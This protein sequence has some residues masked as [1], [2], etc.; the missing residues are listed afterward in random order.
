M[1]A[2][3][4]SSW[5]RL[6]S[7]SSQFAPL[8]PLL[9]IL[10]NELLLAR[11]EGK[12]VS[13]ALL[14]QKHPELNSEEAV[15]L[16]YEEFCLKRD[17]GE[18]VDSTELINKFP[19]FQ[20]QLKTVLE[21]EKLLDQPRPEPVFPEPGTQVGPFH[22]I[23]RLGRGAAGRTYLAQEKSL[24]NRHVV[25]KIMPREQQ[26]HL[27]LARLQHTHIMPLFSELTLP[28]SG[29][30][31]LCMPYLGG[32]GLHEILAGLKE[33]GISKCTG[34]DFL[35]TLDSLSGPEFQ[36]V[37]WASPTRQSLAKSTY[38]DT[39]AS[40]G[41]S[42]A[43]AAHEAHARG[44]V[45]MDIKPS[46]ILIS[47]DSEPLL[48]DFHLARKPV[49]EG[50]QRVD[51]LGGTRGWMSPE[52][53][54]C[55]EAARHGQPM[56][57]SIDG[58]SDQ[59]SIGLLMADAL[60]C[61][62]RDN[63]N[64]WNFNKDVPTGL[65]DIIRRCLAENPANRYTSAAH[66]ADDLNRH[67]ANLPLRGVKNRSLSERWQK[68]KKRNPAGP[69]WFA[70]A[71]ILVAMISNSAYQSWE[72]RS[73]VLAEAAENINDSRNW[74]ESGLHDIAIDRLTETRLTIARIPANDNYLRQ[75]EELLARA[76]RLK[77]ASQL[78]FV[79]DRVR[80]QYGQA[81]LPPATLLKLMQQ[82]QSLWDHRDEL[83]HNNT[84]AETD[85]SNRTNM[86]IK[87]DL[88]ELAVILADLPSR[89]STPKA[90]TQALEIINSAELYLGP[91]YSLTLAR[92][93]LGFS[94]S[95]ESKPLESKTRQKPENAREF[96]QFGQSL[97]RHKRLPEAQLAFAGAASLEPDQFWFQYDLAVCLHQ[98][99]KFDEALA[100]WSAAIALRP[101]S[102]VC[103]YNRGLTWE[104][105]HKPDNALADFQQAA[106]LEPTLAD[107][108]YRA[109]VVL[110]TTGQTSKALA[111]FETASEL[112]EDRSFKARSLFRQT[113]I[114][115]SMQK[116]TEA[117]ATAA[118]ASELGSMEAVDWLRNAPR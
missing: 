25:V 73:R 98:L 44:L 69:V 59:F 65:A 10:L 76:R 16:I 116:P 39:I 66:L 56:P 91:D 1:P 102:A 100:A 71:A 40:I 106:S 5:N 88:I 19:Q 112:A 90:N 2:R 52:Q 43:E 85:F 115:Q 96:H 80:F 4:S 57:C 79:M 23:R 110:N 70:A 14:I 99:K 28:E 64:Q 78:N 53:Y 46:N 75:L 35:S 21:F 82:C 113:L 6:S 62:S 33:K 12:D 3:H 74:I 38:T 101:K 54:N 8:S 104:A 36:R 114:L 107:A 49:N 117:R 93:D 50:E 9:N 51:R 31:L 84:L 86:Q 94:L 92:S 30:R 22:L 109:G 47:A 118:R 26:E 87:T 61:I 29:L 68:W 97:A 60:N 55:F 63:P 7:E 13:A 34:R 95:S 103:R 89:A 83:M 18:V 37:E 58:R 77:L 108:W 48:L 27:T 72:L 11:T 20:D 45:H 67:L 17:D 111:A 15:Q 105:L 32:A 41:A 81:D 42:I 24:G